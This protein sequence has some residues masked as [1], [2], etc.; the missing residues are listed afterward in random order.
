MPAAVHFDPFAY[1]F[2]EDPYPVYRALREHAPVY[3]SPEMG[4]WALSRHA[5]V[6]AGFKD[7]ERLCNS[8]GI[9]LEM[10]DL[11]GDMSAVLSI[12]GM[13]PPRHTRM[14]SLVSRGFTPRRVAELEP[15]VRQMATAYID[16]FIEQGC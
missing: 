10:G 16:R 1:A 2:H 12:L 7:A 11:G 5:D 8:G 14:R 9:S 3:K 15:R 6:V 4:F 13:D